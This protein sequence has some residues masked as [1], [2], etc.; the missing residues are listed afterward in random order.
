MNSLTDNESAHMETI[1]YGGLIWSKISETI[2]PTYIA[3]QPG[4]GG[5]R[6]S[7]Y[8]CDGLDWSSGKWHWHADLDGLVKSEQRPNVIRMNVGGIVP[9]MMEAMLA[10]LDAR[11]AFVEDLRQLLYLLCPGEEYAQGRRAGQEEIKQR[12]ID[13][14]Q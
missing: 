8:P 9:T 11:G 13:F 5:L 2:L 1:E 3:E 4:V 12:M 7:Q 14:L 10:C 6:V